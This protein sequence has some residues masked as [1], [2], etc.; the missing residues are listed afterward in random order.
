M[1]GD[2]MCCLESWGAILLGAVHGA[3]PGRQAAGQRPHIETQ[4]GNKRIV[5]SDFLPDLLKG[6][7][8][9]P[10]L[11]VRLALEMK[12]VIEDGSLQHIH[13]DLCSRQGIS[14]V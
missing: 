3:W 6:P 1:H 4:G 12:A 10:E 5:A 14:E 9:Y 8:A 7:L 11:A 13:V 2:E